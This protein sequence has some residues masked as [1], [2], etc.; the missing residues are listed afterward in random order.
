MPETRSNLAA[1][2]IRVFISLC[3]RQPTTLELHVGETMFLCHN[4]GASRVITR[5]Q[6]SFEKGLSNTLRIRGPTYPEIPVPR[7]S[8]LK[9]GGR[10]GK[11]VKRYSMRH[12]ASAALAN[13]HIKQLYALIGTRI[14]HAALGVFPGLW[15]ADDAK[16]PMADL[17]R[18]DL[19]TLSG[20]PKRSRAPHVPPFSFLPRPMQ[21]PHP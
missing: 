11:S 2:M 6:E 19:T 18:T 20:T 3:D 13:H 5:L 8:Y 10:S 14:I 4:Q 17:T 7:E 15:V 16:P 21:Y 9:R 1:S 12:A